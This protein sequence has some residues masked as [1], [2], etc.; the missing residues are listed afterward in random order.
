MIYFKM[1]LIFASLYLLI[2]LIFKSS[3][4][5][6]I[7]CMLFNIFLLSS[8]KRSYINLKLSFDIF[9]AEYFLYILLLVIPFSNSY[10][11]QEN[12]SLRF[13]L[14]SILF[15]ELFIRL[16]KQSSKN[17]RFGL[18]KFAEVC[19]I[20]SL[21]RFTEIFYVCREE[22][23]LLKCSQNIFST[24]LTKLSLNED[25]NS[26]NSYYGFIIINLIVMSSVIFYLLKSSSIK[27]V[28]RINFMV[29]VKMFLLLAYWLI[30]LVI[31]VYQN[32]SDYQLQ[33]ISLFIARTFYICFLVI[34]VMLFRDNK[35]STKN[36]LSKVY[37]R[38]VI[39]S[40]I[41]WGLLI[42]LL[43]VESLMSI[44]ILILIF[45]V[46]QN[47]RQSWNL[48]KFLGLNF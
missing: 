10:I 20:T 1:V 47:Y 31:N 35:M 32:G 18:M 22:A 40:M 19:F 13:I 24:Q 30:Q 42:S 41:S 11:V 16:R 34:Q 4:N 3:M 14:V 39:Y 36:N 27:M 48:S 33:N 6:P 23:L 28:S 2:S 46:Y 45:Q 37:L 7:I 44:W 8:F 29:I 9:K 5:L 21:I 26:I 38:T 15:F 12:I 17:A 43:S 25:Q